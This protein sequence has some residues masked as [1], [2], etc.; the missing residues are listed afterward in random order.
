MFTNKVK[1][2]FSNI[3]LNNIK[4][5]DIEGF[6]KELE[7]DFNIRSITFTFMWTI[8]LFIMVSGLVNYSPI[9]D[10]WYKTSK[11]E[12]MYWMLGI[13]LMLV[14]YFVLFLKLS[15]KLVMNKVR[16]YR[17][18]EVLLKGQKI[19]QYFDESIFKDNISEMSD[20]VI[21]KEG[22]NHC[23][24]EL[25]LDDLDKFLKDKGYTKDINIRN[26]KIKINDM[27]DNT[28]KLF[29]FLELVE[30]DVKFKIKG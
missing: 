19:T 1:I 14:S 18:I 8:I 9:G 27:I 3:D 2:Y 10:G 24:R 11:L 6:S 26:N 23:L 30:K 7:R 17:S 5:T 28:N 22:L 16:D 15:D 13:F 4:D 12:R 20:W 29:D 25:K 21:K